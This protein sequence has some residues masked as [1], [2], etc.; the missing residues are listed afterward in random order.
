MSIMVQEEEVRGTKN[1]LFLCLPISSGVKTKPP[2]DFWVSTEDAK[3]IRKKTNIMLQ[4]SFANEL[5]RLTH[6]NDEK[7]PI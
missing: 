5:W 6:A 4:T 1:E 7:V 2:R 3:E